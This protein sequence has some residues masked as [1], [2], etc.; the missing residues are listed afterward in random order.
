MD[1]A[2]VV[3]KRTLARTA[4]GSVVLEGGRLDR[5]ESSDVQRS[6]PVSASKATSG[7]MSIVFESA[8]PR[9]ERR[10]V[11]DGRGHR[12]LGPRP[13]R[14]DDIGT[15]D[16]SAYIGDVPTGDRFG[17]RSVVTVATGHAAGE[18]AHTVRE[19]RPARDPVRG[20]DAI[21]GRERDPFRPNA[22]NPYV[23]TG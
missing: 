13:G 15:A 12:H 14:P 9:D 18:S 1:R 21:D 5:S 23:R 22:D 7:G 6:A 19:H 17:R 10:S 4:D 2:C 20:R 11:A 3:L 8:V 16:G